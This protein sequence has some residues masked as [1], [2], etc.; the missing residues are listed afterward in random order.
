MLLDPFKQFNLPA[1]FEEDSDFKGRQIKI[2]RQKDKLQA[3]FKV[4]LNQRNQ[5]KS[6]RSRN[7]YK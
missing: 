6:S 5:F 3:C 1:I 7:A 4:I 2:I